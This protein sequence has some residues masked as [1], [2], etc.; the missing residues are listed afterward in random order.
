MGGYDQWGN[1]VTA[2]ELSRRMGCGEAFAMTTRLITKAD[3]TKFGKTEGGNVW[4]DP[5]L[6]SPYK[7]YQFWLNASDEDVK[8]YVRIFTLATRV[9]IETLEAEH[10]KTPHQRLLQKY[11]AKD[12]TTR[13]HS[14]EDYET[15]VKASEILFGNATSQTLNELPE[16][17]LLGVLE[18]V[19]RF[20]LSRTRSEEHTSELQSLM[21]ISYA[22]F[23]LKQKRE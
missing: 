3:G 7:F 2:T 20:E 6:T 5:A 11:L 1:I 16:S 19:H 21:R 22:V 8:K 4:L 9:E 14:A 23:C 18:G 17:A 10:D 13:V 12:I 15:S